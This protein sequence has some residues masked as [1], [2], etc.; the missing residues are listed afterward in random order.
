MPLELHPNPGAQADFLRS[1]ARFPAL[2]MGQGGG[3]TWGGA[4]KLLAHH[5]HVPGVDSLVIEPTYSL[6]SQVA[7]P[8][9]VEH[10]RAAEIPFE[11]RLNPMEISTPATDNRILIYSGTAPERIT[12]FEVGRTWIDEPAR[13]PEHASPL[14]NLWFNALARTRDPRVASHLRQIM[15]TGTHEGKASWLWLRWEKQ[16][17]PGFAIFRGATTDNPGMRA[18]AALMRAEYG[19]DLANQYVD[20]WAVEDTTAVMAWADI[21]ACQRAGIP[22]SLDLAV[23]LNQ[24]GPLFAGIDIGRTQSLTVIW[25]IRAGAGEIAGYETVG[26]VEMR[27]VSFRDQAAAINVLGKTPAVACIAIDATYNPQTAEDAVGRFGESP[28]GAILPVVFTPARKLSLV[29]RLQKAVQ[30]HTISLPDGDDVAMD[31][32]GL[33]RVVSTGGVV[34]YAAPFTADGHSDRAIAAALALEAAAAGYAGPVEVTRGPPL[35]SS[36]LR[37]M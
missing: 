3:K 15:V 36:G 28:R 17:R 16:A 19:P 32:Y 31:F 20:G 29:Q 1:A 14:R 25:I 11:V 23:L 2:I 9:L 6:A 18:Q 7:I 22:R 13:I 34:T 30:T 12:G 37:G 35:R 8:A 24:A 27:G 4:A 5:V 10:L 21:L 26:I 33:K